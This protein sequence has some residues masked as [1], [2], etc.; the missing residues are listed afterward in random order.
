MNRTKFRLLIALLSS[1]WLAYIIKRRRDG[2]RN[3]RLKVENAGKEGEDNAVVP[4]SWDQS[5]RAPSYSWDFLLKWRVIRFGILNFCRSVLRRLLQT[6]RLPLPTTTTSLLSFLLPPEHVDFHAL[7]R[8]KRWSGAPTSS[9]EAMVG[10]TP[11]LAITVRY[12]GKIRTIYAKCEQYNLT[13]SVKDRMALHI[14]K[15]SYERGTIKR[16]DVIIE[17][18]SGNTGISFAAMG[19]ALGHP[20]VIFMPDW[21]SSERR[22]LIKSYGAQVVPVSA[23]QG[24]FI[25]SIQMVEETARVH[26]GKGIFLARQFENTLNPEAHRLSTGPEIVMQLATEQLQPHCF[27]AGVGT[28]GTVQGVSESFKSVLPGVRV[29]PVEPAESPTLS[30]GCHVGDHRIQ[31]IS[32]EFVP[33]VVNLAGLDAIIPVPDGDAILMAQK[34][35]SELGLGVGIS[36]GANLLA[37]LEAQERLSPDAVAVT[38]FCDDNKKYLTTALTGKEP[39]RP[40]YRTPHVELQSYRVIPPLSPQLLATVRDGSWAQHYVA[41]GRPSPG[42]RQASPGLPQSSPLSGA[43]PAVR[44][45]RKTPLV[46][47]HAPTQAQTL[48]E[49]SLLASGV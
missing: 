22:Q 4:Q 19:R 14:L 39:V 1:A 29:H 10:N 16:G 24:G 20:V 38:I 21:M 35:A 37:A 33:P 2:R 6:L 27:V 12:M 26:K 8:S 15:T 43:L 9:L 36:S 42:T 49:M 5:L 41:V 46:R 47:T 11:L 44:R 30:V 28:G 48:A 45:Q 32:D 13:G 18:S 31:G 23:L 25:G 3:S 7:F 34:L 17:A 40:G